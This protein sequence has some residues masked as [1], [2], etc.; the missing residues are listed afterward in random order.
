MSERRKENVPSGDHAPDGPTDAS[1]GALNQKAET[2]KDADPAPAPDAGVRG[3]EEKEDPSL[4][5]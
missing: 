1:A 3:R 2:G 5:G 4:G